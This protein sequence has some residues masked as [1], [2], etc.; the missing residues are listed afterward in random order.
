MP[1]SPVPEPWLDPATAVDVA[2][3]N[4]LDLKVAAGR[5]E[6]AQR[7]VV[8]AADRLRPELTSGGRRPGPVRTTSSRFDG[9]L[10][11]LLSG[12]TVSTAG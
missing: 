4:R 7:Q 1:T 11:D 2:L 3:A 5:I 8:I 12:K 10:K 9:T 6:D